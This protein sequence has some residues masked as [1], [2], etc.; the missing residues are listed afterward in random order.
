MAL[1]LILTTLSGDFGYVEEVVVDEAA[2]GR[3]ISTEL[4]R[5][6]LNLAAQKQ[7]RFVDLTSHP[8]TTA[9]NGLYRSLGFEL[10]ETNCYRYT[11]ERSTVPQ[12]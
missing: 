5:E 7:L 4:M 12:T 2:S 10:R 6:L 11:P 9:A 1:L 3:H 8:S